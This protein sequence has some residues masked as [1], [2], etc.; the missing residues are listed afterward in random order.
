MARVR[1]DWPARLLSC[2]RRGL[3]TVVDTRYLDAV[4]SWL[5]DLEHG[6][7]AMAQARADLAAFVRDIRQR[8]TPRV[9]AGQ[10]Q[11]RNRAASALAVLGK[12]R[13]ELDGVRLVLV[14]ARLSPDGEGDYVVTAASYVRASLDPLATARGGNVV[15]IASR[16]RAS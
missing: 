4:W 10:E 3:S 1:A 8:T 5:L 7:L 14:P 12:E 13:Y 15:D 9:C 6:R 2:P 16:R 11:L